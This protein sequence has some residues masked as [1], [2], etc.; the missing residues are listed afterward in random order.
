MSACFVR[1]VLVLQDAAGAPRNSRE[2]EQEV[3]FQVEEGLAVQLQRDR[4][5]AVVRVESEAGDAAVGGDV[6]VLL[7]DGLLEA[8]DL[9]LAGQ[10]G[11]MAGQH[12]LHPVCAQRREAAPW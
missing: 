8:V 4:L 1:C 7:A 12:G 11:Q 2:E 3:V 5:D 10:S 6:L 9:D